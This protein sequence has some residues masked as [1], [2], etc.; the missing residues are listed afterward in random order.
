MCSSRS[1]LV[2][3]L[4]DVCPVLQGKVKRHLVTW[5]YSAAK[6]KRWDSWTLNGDEFVMELQP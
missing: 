1:G 6:V 5:R 3:Q 4:I 2:P